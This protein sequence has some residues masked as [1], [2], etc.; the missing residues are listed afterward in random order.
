[1]FFFINSETTKVSVLHDHGL[2]DMIDSDL[3]VKFC[4]IFMSE[5][6]RKLILL[7][8][9]F[10][11]VLMMGNCSSK[12]LILRVFRLILKSEPTILICRGLQ[13]N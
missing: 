6:R 7:R 8:D 1:M 5:N 10:V 9:S 13:V 11:H 2:A 12:I 4:V 3:I